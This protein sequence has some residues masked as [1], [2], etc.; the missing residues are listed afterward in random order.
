MQIEVIK[1]ENNE[2]LTRKQL[3]L[4]IQHEA[5]TP[6]RLEV[7]DKV[8]ADFKIAPERVII[9]NM[10]TAFGKKETTA[11]VKIY[12]SAE[13]ARQIEQAHI[14]KRNTPPTPEPSAEPTSEPSA[15]PTAEPTSE[16][17]AEPS[18]EP[19]PKPPEGGEEN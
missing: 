13:A 17:S 19:S 10:Q 2:L 14:L 7:R 16:P 15:E 18:A 9:D 12:E 4:K 8:A 5:A 6:A 11:Y 1:E 3:Q